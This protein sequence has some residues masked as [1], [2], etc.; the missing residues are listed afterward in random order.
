MSAVEIEAETADAALEQ[1][2]SGGH[3]HG[4]EVWRG[5]ELLIRARA[6]SGAPGAGRAQ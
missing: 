6:G 5:A 2:L 3:P 4:V 1:A